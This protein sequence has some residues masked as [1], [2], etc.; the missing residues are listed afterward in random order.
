VK[1]FFPPPPK[2]EP[3]Y[4]KGASRVADDAPQKVEVVASRPEPPEL[5]GITEAVRRK[6]ETARIAREVAPLPI[7]RNRF[8]AA[9]LDHPRL[10]G[11]VA[12]VVFGALFAV[13]VYF[14]QSIFWHRRR[15]GGPLMFLALLAGAG[16]WL[17]LWGIPFDKDRGDVP[18]WWWGGLGVFGIGSAAT[19]DMWKM[20][21]LD[22]L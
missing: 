6:A 22:H 1:P 3:P 5:P 4:R 8:W 21:L 15:G 10:V 14:R 9:L 7:T 13:A 2:A 17:A 16:L 18:I 19:S 20:V 11:A 12:F